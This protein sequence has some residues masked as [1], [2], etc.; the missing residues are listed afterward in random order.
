ML[1]LNQTKKLIFST[2]ICLCLSILFSQAVKAIPGCRYMSRMYYNLVANPPN[3][4]YE[5]YT[6]EY[7]V[8]SNTAFDCNSPAYQNYTYILT[9][10]TGSRNSKGGRCYVNYS[11]GNVLGMGYSFAKTYQCPIDDYVPYLLFA[12]LPLSFYFSRKRLLLS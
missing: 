3:N 1:P 5:Y 12:L 8:I 7:W 9:K 6:D 10:D 2:F 4:T 11:N